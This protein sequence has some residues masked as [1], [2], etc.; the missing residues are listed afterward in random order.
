MKRG[1][2]EAVMAPHCELL[3]SCTAGK[4]GH[5]QACLTCCRAGTDTHAAPKG[6]PSFLSSCHLWAVT[7]SSS[8]AGQLAGN[9]AVL[10]ALSSAHAEGHSSGAHELRVSSRLLLN[11]E[12]HCRCTGSQS[13][14]SPVLPQHLSGTHCID[15]VTLQTSRKNHSSQLELF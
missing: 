9:S 10:S 12:I 11:T 8:K 5:T 14:S 4:S 7:Q 15:Q 2:S 13:S 3:P 6:I 1:E